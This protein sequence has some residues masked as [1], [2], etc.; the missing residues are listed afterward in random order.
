MQF[1]FDTL[2]YDHSIY[3]MEPSKSIVSNQKD[4]IYLNGSCATE[5][6]HT[7]ARTRIRAPAFTI[8]RASSV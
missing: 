7:H 5:H 8:L 2:N 4:N 6:T 3:T 1:Y